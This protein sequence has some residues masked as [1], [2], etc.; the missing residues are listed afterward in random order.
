MLVSGCHCGASAFV[1]KQSQEATSS[2][3]RGEAEAMRSQKLSCVNVV[4]GERE[5]RRV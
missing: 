2:W 1:L 5:G 4:G 3:V